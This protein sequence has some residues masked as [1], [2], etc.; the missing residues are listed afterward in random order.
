MGDHSTADNR[1]AEVFGIRE[2]VHYQEGAVVSR[3]IVKKPTGTVTFFAFA[4]GQGLSEHTVPF[5]ALVQVTDGTAEISIDGIPY[6]VEEGEMIIMP[7]NVP[8]AV[9]AVTGFKMILVMIK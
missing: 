3:E 4:E 6:Q 2:L 1:T 5:D 7:A 9:A 8:H